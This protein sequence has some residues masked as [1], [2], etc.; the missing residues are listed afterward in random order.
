[1]SLSLSK[2]SPRK[3]QQSN[4][5]LHI[6]LPSEELIKKLSFDSNTTASDL[7][8]SVFTQIRSLVEP[9]LQNFSEKE[10]EVPSD[11]LTLDVSGSHPTC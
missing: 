2:R 1:M 11:W 3:K 9:K 4:E 6:S 7:F 5:N 10:D 8:E